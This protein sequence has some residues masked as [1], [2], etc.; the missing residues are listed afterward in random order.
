MR[1]AYPQLVKVSNR[2]FMETNNTKWRRTCEAL[3]GFDP[4]NHVSN[5][6]W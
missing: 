6:I 2:N 1:D 3:L 4:S 5:D